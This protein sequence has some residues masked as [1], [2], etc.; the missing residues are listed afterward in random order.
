MAPKAEDKVD[1]Q[2]EAVMRLRIRRM[3]K[4]EAVMRMKIRSVT[5]LRLS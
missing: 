1:D 4:A 3:T 5:N 2:A